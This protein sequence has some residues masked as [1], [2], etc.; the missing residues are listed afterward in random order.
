[1]KREKGFLLFCIF[2]TFTFVPCRLIYAQE[3]C[4]LPP[5][6]LLDFQTALDAKDAGNDSLA[7]SRME[8]IIREFQGSPGPYYVLGN[9]YW[10]NNNKADALRMWKMARSASPT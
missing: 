5:V 10:E 1:M 4:E 6:S 3:T 2:L 7:I 9:W 8:D